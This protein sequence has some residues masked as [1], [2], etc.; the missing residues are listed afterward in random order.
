[1][2]DLEKFKAYFN[3]HDRFSAKNGM[4]ATE[5]REGYARV[6]LTVGEESKNFMGSMHGGLLYTMADVAAGLAMVAYGKQV[7]TL[8]GSMEYIKAAYGGRVVAEGKVVA[9]GKTIARCEV[10]LCGEDGT[11]YGKSHLTMFI[12]DNEI[13]ETFGDS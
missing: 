2:I 4:R 11:L 5:I 7:V 10:K 8:N 13:P 6:E 12:M 9:C 3:E 1:M